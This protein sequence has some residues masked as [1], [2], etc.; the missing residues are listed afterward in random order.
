MRRAGGAGCHYW[1]HEKGWRCWM[2]LLVVCSISLEGEDGT[3][4]LDYSKNIITKETM[5]LL[6]NLVRRCI[7]LMELP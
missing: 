4:L 2:S 1:L 3:I 5:K 6:F 7:G